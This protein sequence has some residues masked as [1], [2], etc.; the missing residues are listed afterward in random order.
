M[1][2]AHA[3]AQKVRDARERIDGCGD[4][5]MLGLDKCWLGKGARINDRIQSHILRNKKDNSKP[6]SMEDGEKKIWR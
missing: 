4:G 6:Y 3:Y 5:G 1:R 2:N